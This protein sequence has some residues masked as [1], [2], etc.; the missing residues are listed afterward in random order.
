MHRW[1]DA[2]MKPEVEVDGDLAARAAAIAETHGE[3][4]EDVI[5][6]LLAEYVTRGE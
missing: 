4:L 2:R 3:R 1:Y 5:A 6:R